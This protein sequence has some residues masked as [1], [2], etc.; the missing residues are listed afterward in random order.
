[1]ESIRVIFP[2]FSERNGNE[3]ISNHNNK[4]T[5]TKMKKKKKRSMKQNVRVVSPYF[6]NSIKSAETSNNSEIIIVVSKKTNVSTCGK[7]DHNE[8][9][10]KKRR[11]K[12][13]D[14]N[15]CM[16]SLE[17]SNS[18][19][20][21]T[22]SDNVGLRV[23]SHY[24]AKSTSK[25]DVY[26]SEI[27]AVAK[28]KTDK[29]KKSREEEQ[30]SGNKNYNKK[31][32]R[33]RRSDNGQCR[34]KAFEEPN[35]LEPSTKE[36]N[37][38]FGKSIF[39]N[40]INLQAVSHYFVKGTSDDSETVV[41]AK[42]CNKEIEEQESEK[43]KRRTKKSYDGKYCIGASEEPN[44]LDPQTERKN[45]KLRRERVAHKEKEKEMEKKYKNE[46]R[47]E[48]EEKKTRK[49]NKKSNDDDDRS[50]QAS[51]E[52]NPSVVQTERTN[53][54]LDDLFS[55]FVYIGPKISNN[56]YSK[57]LSENRH[58]APLQRCVQTNTLSAAEKVSDAYRRVG[59]DNTW[60][61]P[62]SSY[63]L[64]QEDHVHDPWRVL[65]ICFLLNRTSGLQVCFYSLSLSLIN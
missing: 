58:N 63:N 3:N 24:F 1:M 43:E 37:V 30:E 20:I 10:K 22:M 2:Y 34:I 47:K 56:K 48:K 23:V 13:D 25:E 28:K 50:V 65:I 60:K 51:E 64:L 40:D 52:P 27:V 6:A 53:V 49:R 59:P 8:R 57:N 61:P 46:K 31:R 39:P 21:Q 4:E 42:N 12:S 17:G 7:R 29:N 55:R 14:G 62:R 36:V 35:L 16:K 41:V 19:N 11:K 54:N 9:Q 15:C 44:L 18:S 5:N 32:Y 45:S 33:K 38:K 26:G